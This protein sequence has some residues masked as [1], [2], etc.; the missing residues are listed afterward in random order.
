MDFRQKL[1]AGFLSLSPV[2]KR[3]LRTVV[4]LEKSSEYLRGCVFG[5]LRLSDV[6]KLW[7]NELRIDGAS[8]RSD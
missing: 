4:V 1:D 5:K 6:G 8:Q 3:R 7:I 2:L